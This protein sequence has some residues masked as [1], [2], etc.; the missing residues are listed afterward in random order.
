MFKGAKRF[1]NKTARVIASLL[2]LVMI[3]LLVWVIFS[4]GEVVVH[5]MFTLDE[6]CQYCSFNLFNLM[7][8]H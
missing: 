1:I 5:N 4:V 3:V 7:M 8:N 2:Y 6:P